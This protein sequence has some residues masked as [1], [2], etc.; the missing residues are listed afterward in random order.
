[1]L[2]AFLSPSSVAHLRAQIANEAGVDKTTTPLRNIWLLSPSI[3]RAFRN[4][5]VALRLRGSRFNPSRKVEPDQEFAREIQNAWCV[6]ETSY[7][8]RVSGLLLGD[9]T[10]LRGMVGFQFSTPDPQ[11]LP[12]PSIFLFEVHRRFATALH[13]FS[14]E[15]TIARGWPQ[16]PRGS[17]DLLGFD[18]PVLRQVFFSSIWLYIPSWLRLR[19][20]LLLGRFGRWFYGLGIEPSVQR[21]PFGL[22][23]KTCSRYAS[24]SQNEPNAL[25]L[26]E[27]YASSIPA[28]RVVDVGKY[29][30]TT[31]LLMTRLRGQMLNEVL[32]LMSYTERDRFADDLGFYVA[33]LRRQI[34]NITTDTNTNKNQKKGGYI[35]YNNNAGSAVL[36]CNTLGGPVVD[37]RLP[38]GSNDDGSAGPFHSESDF[39][40]HL[41]SH[42]RCSL[43]EVVG[44]EKSIRYDHRSCFTHSDLHYTNLLVDRGRLSGIVD[45][46]CAGFLPEYWEFTKAMYGTRQHPVLEAIIRRAFSTVGLQPYEAELEVERKLWACTPF[47]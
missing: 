6:L 35:D 34:P 16:Q 1:M 3:H 10:P 31:Y 15:D 23:L 36:F 7:P 44:E 38:S 21:L 39:N 37:H 17:S 13:L 30:G 9:G 27:R 5:H 25:Q 26:V 33:Q 45:W 18:I 2:E 32:H 47:G 12:T 43:A 19:C 14:I 41:T 40:A 8:G 42:L 11:T 4:G 28:P 29:N 22:V 20:Y 24:S 46:E